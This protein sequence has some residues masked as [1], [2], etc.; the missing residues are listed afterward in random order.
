MSIE[1]SLLTTVLQ[2]AKLQGLD[3]VRLAERAGLRAET[4][5]RAKR[6]GSIDLSSLNALAAAVGLRLA[7][8]S[9]ASAS[10]AV[11]EALTLREPAPRSP[12]AHPKWGLAWSNPNASHEALI[13]NALLHGN[14]DLL[15]QAVLGHGLAAVKRQW[16]HAAPL[17]P[18]RARQEVE[19][20]LHNIEK[21]LTDAAA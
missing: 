2:T 13:H 19:R 8:V 3:Q 4:I 1:S 21:G 11:G 15:L 7:L 9:D 16:Q 10:K 17:L 18:A 12:L 20:K 14:Y 6:R 5:S